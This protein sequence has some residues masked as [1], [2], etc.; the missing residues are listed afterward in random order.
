MSRDTVAD[1]KAF[2]DKY[3]LPFSLLAD[4]DHKVSEAFGVPSTGNYA[5]RQAFLIHDGK[6]VQARPRSF[7]RR[8]GGRRAGR[9]R[10]GEEAL[11]NAGMKLDAAG[12]RCCRELC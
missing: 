10:P 8:A 1:Q 2:Q 5:A 7:D 11:R 9:A 3:H 4:T 12:G 6:V